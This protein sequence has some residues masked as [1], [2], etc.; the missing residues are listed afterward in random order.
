MKFKVLPLCTRPLLVGASVRVSPS[1]PLPLKKKCLECVIKAAVERGRGTRLL[2]VCVS[3]NNDG[4]L[5]L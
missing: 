3:C 1:T 5:L 4:L 2:C